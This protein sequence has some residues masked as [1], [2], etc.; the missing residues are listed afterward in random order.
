MPTNSEPVL[1]TML[2]FTMI[3]GTIISVV[4]VPALLVSKQFRIVA[5]MTVVIL[6]AIAADG[7]IHTIASMLKF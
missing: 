7:A 2:D 6:G 5:K 4:A 3:V 1:L